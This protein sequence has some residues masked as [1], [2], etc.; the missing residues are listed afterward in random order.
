MTRF[1]IVMKLARI[2]K[3]HFGLDA[4]TLAWES[5]KVVRSTPEET[6]WEIK[7]RDDPSDFVRLTISR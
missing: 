1:E 6:T 2:V 7:R 5:M 3:T 4:M